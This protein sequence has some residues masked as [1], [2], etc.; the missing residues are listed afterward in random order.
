[1]LALTVV[2]A[3]ALVLPNAAE[4]APVRNGERTVP[5]VAAG[6]DSTLVARADGTVWAWGD[7]TL[8]QLGNG[9]VTS[10][11]T[12]T[13]V[14][15]AAATPLTDV[16]ALAQGCGTS[17]AV[18]ADGA[19]FAWGS[20]DH[21]Q[22][23]IGTATGPS[24]CGTSQCS[25]YAIRVQVGAGPTWLTGVTDVTAGA[26]FAIARRSDGTA[27]AWGRGSSGQLGNQSTSGPATCAGQ[28]CSAYAIQVQDPAA[29]SGLLTS[30]VDVAAGDATAIARLA[31][32][33]LVAWGDSS[34]GATGV[35]TTTGTTLAP[36]LVQ[37][38]SGTYPAVDR[39]RDIDGAGRTFRA[40]RSDGTLLSWGAGAEGQLGNATTTAAQPRAVEVLDPTLATPLTRV[41]SLG[42][43]P[44]HGIVV[45]ADGSTWAW[46]RNV[47][48]QVGDVSQVQRSR[49]VQVADSTTPTYLS[50]TTRVDGGADHSVAVRADGTIWTWGNDRAGQLGLATAPAA[51][52]GGEPCSTYARAGQVAVGSGYVAVAAAHRTSYAVRAD[53]T[54]WS[55]GDSRDGELGIG[56]E[57]G[58][59]STPQQVMVAAATPLDGVIA[60][61]GGAEHAHALR[62]DGS[63]WSWG[64][65]AY[66]QLGR[67]S[68]SDSNWAVQMQ[69]SSGVNLADV[70]QVG[71]VDRATL[72]LG[73]DGRVR[74]VG[75]N[76]FGTL[77]DNTTSHRTYPV[78]SQLDGGA[79]LD[80]VV[81]LGGDGGDVDVALAVRDDGTAWSWGENADGELGIGT[82]VGPDSCGNSCSRQAMQVLARAGVPFTGVLQASGGYET[83]HLMTATGAAYSW[84]SNET[85]QIGNA[86][87]STTDVLFPR[88]VST[89]AT[90]TAWLVGARAI[91]AGDYS[92][93]AIGADG[94]ILGW[95][96][97]VHGQLGDGTT[98]SPRT[99]AIPSA[100]VG[101]GATAPLVTDLTSGE[102]HGI[103]RDASGRV[104]TWGRDGNGQLGACSSTYQ[105]RLYP[106]VVQWSCGNRPPFATPAWQYRTDGTNLPIG[107]WTNETTIRVGTDAADPDNGEMLRLFVEIRPVGTPF[108]AT[109]GDAANPAV[110][111]SAA[112]GPVALGVEEWIT[113]DVTGLVSGT[114]YRWRSCVVDGGGL[115]GPWYT[116]EGSPHIAIDT[117]TPPAGTFGTRQ[118][119]AGCDNTGVVLADGTAWMAGDGALGQLGNGT[120]SGTSATPVQ[121]RMAPAGAEPLTD[122]R[123][124]SVGCDFA[125]AVRADG[126][127][128][129]WGSNAT[130][131]LGAAAATTCGATP[132]SPW[133]TQVDAANVTG[134]KEVA[135]GA[136]FA[137]ALRADGRVMGWGDNA[138]GQ[139]G[140]GST[141]AATATAGFVRD[142]AG[143]ADLMGVVSIGAGNGFAVASDVDG[144]AW[145]WGSNG[146]DRLGAGLTTGTSYP[147]ARR[148]LSAAATPLTRVK[149][150]AAGSAHALALR[151]DGTLWGWGQNT[152]G[153]VGVNA[154]GASVPYASAVRDS[155][156]TTMTRFADLAPGA[157]HNLALRADGT[158]W[159]WG[160][161]SAGQ[162][163]RATTVGGSCAGACEAYPRPI[164]DSAG[165]DLTVDGSMFK[166][167]AAGDSH[168]VSLR[169][170]GRA[171]A[172][173]SDVDGQLARGA[174]VGSSTSL[175]AT[176][177]STGAGVIHVSARDFGGAVVIADGTVRSWGDGAF[178]Q[179]GNGEAHGQTP[180]LQTVEVSAGVPLADVVSLGSGALASYALRADGTVWAWGEGADGRLGNNGTSDRL[181]AVQVRAA[182]AT[183]DSG[184][185]LVDVLQVAGHDEG[186]VAVDSAGQAW[187]WG[188]NESGEL[189]DGTCCSDRSYAAPA[190]VSAG[191]PLDRV[192]SI[193]GAAV[194]GDEAY[195]VRSDGT[196][197]AWGA[198][199]D[200]QL[201]QGSNV[202]PQTCGS[203]PCSTYALQV[204]GTSTPTA[205]TGVAQITAADGTGYVRK[206]DGTVW[207]WGEGALGALGNNGTSDRSYPVQVRSTS[208]STDTGTPLSGVVAMGGGEESG[209]VV[210]SDGTVRS[211]GRNNNAQLGDLSTTD[212]SYA[213]AS[214]GRAS[215]ALPRML[216]TDA[217]GGDH[218]VLLDAT[219]RVHTAGGNGYYQLADCMKLQRAYF[220]PIR[221]SCPGNRPP[222]V[223]W[224]EQ[225]DSTSA[226]IGLGAWTPDGATTNITI[227]LTASDPDDAET[228]TPYLELAPVGTALVADCGDTTNPNVRAGTALNLP[229]TGNGDPQ[230]WTITGLTV[231][232]Q[233][234]WRVCA[235]DASGAAS[236]W[237][238]HGSV[239]FP[240]FGVDDSPPAN[241]TRVDDGAERDVDIDTT[242]S[243]NTIEA[244]WPYGID[245][246]GSGLVSYDYCVTTDPA[247]A[248]CG[249]GAVRAWTYNGYDPELRATGLTLT[250][251]SRYHVCVRAVD[252]AGNRAIGHVCSDGQQVRFAFTAVNPNAGVQGESGVRVELTGEGFLPTDT[253]AFSGTGI[254]VQSITRISDTRIDVVIDIAAGATADARDVTVART[255]T[256][257]SRVTR[258]GAFTVVA[259]S[260]TINVSTLGY[261]D[262]ARDATA[263]NAV[264]FGS[265][266]PGDVR[267]I[268]PAGSGQAIAGAAAEVTVVS[269]GPWRLQASGSDFSDGT[270][271]VPAS[272]LSWKHFGVTEAWTPFATSAAT[273]EG[274]GAGNAANDPAGTTYGYDWQMAIP[275]GQAP[276]A[277]SGTVTYTAIPAV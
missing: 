14:L 226:I 186:A 38:D 126:T 127:V 59:T 41:R 22:L 202:G 230:V 199:D 194:D 200:G 7:N 261:D 34:D 98:Q 91:A 259:L 66:G 21:G 3:A 190:R 166:S 162:L 30:V 63:V 142:T 222:D 68:T 2:L 31:N 238:Q 24:T 254:T 123:S 173:G 1:M 269:N 234:H 241:P 9:S 113:V 32:G 139:L 141:S 15:V 107:T 93:V 81:A 249:A 131:Q 17:Y 132:C 250:H 272:A 198:N 79:P 92:P 273:I 114:Q 276:G 248:D 169:A 82:S 205:L 129:A 4:A 193:G 206:A 255:G 47:W 23:G 212:R 122:V 128:W 85:G 137:L 191:T 182:A 104:L 161:S 28:A 150:A 138:V 201:G 135:A 78:Q 217:N 13:Q 149:Q 33:T 37:L 263:P 192:V 121:V 209:H 75:R 5:V 171:W 159:A 232:T 155:G 94:G 256:D 112:E 97:N 8:G 45:R 231:G 100:G 185:P 53:G 110:F 167:I 12:P 157:R 252:G 86:T 213:V 260:V 218:A 77:A 224:L 105:P 258:T 265:M 54:V 61:V 27:W 204:R 228:V 176:E 223:R 152:S 172:W 6:C 156:G 74:A 25:H 88:A 225:R 43:G 215:S 219:G 216:T 163:G 240:S 178:G 99:Y 189:A 236:A 49:P 101:G 108:G 117:S 36:T 70:V 158:V 76:S 237:V 210:L 115:A 73:V 264:G 147:T 10:S 64:D 67:G 65:G 106:D 44:G 208:G 197:W 146:D 143:T 50:L 235:V 151:D 140:R 83:A 71:T 11:S 111:A 211:W 244:T 153:Q 60:I 80:R 253:V 39:V 229:R 69:A 56:V 274:A 271:T 164:T 214:L 116:P 16:I 262:T 84:G 203:A 119:S 40:L 188:E 102:D 95:G 242:Y 220:E 187:T 243:L 246:G 133:A 145:A 181:R 19:V 130:S 168:S 266:L 134:I 124:L 96:N 57:D 120:T 165:V 72:L 257:T 20:N 245:G 62:A 51:C 180:R 103:A 90:N 267:Q 177:F 270:D 26:G 109:C 251:G 277:Y 48:G 174:A 144:A 154:V 207:S 52:T 239:P 268:G 89:D 233:Y 46:G 29:T 42:G 87:S 170:A 184:T 183:T 221:L 148:V 18:R 175:V 275:A 160:E 179:L 247:G 58:M 118:V 136:G 55:W 195:A 125:V 35:G 227:R 196:A